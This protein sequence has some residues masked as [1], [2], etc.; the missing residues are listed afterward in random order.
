MHFKALGVDD[1]LWSI[2]VLFTAV[3]I[4]WIPFSLFQ[5][6]PG[7]LG[8]DGSLLLAIVSVKIVYEYTF[9]YK[10]QPT[11]L[12]LD[13]SINNLPFLFPAGCAA[14]WPRWTPWSG[15]SSTR[16]RSSPSSS[17]G[18][19]KDPCIYF[20]AIYVLFWHFSML[21][22]GNEILLRLLRLDSTFSFLLR[23]L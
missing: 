3:L 20:L 19:E 12:L 6:G 16:R 7:G 15:R 21:E 23:L 10:H 1:S 2:Y 17:T 13:P 9:K 14:T 4:S 5:C 8:P 22:S 11:F 18:W